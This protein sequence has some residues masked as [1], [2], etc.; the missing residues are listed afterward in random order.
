MS[1][2]ALAKKI[3]VQLSAAGSW[4]LRFRCPRLQCLY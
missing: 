4:Q 2:V 1:N 3:H